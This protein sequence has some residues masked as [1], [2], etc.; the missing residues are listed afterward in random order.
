MKL[1]TRHIG[2][3]ITAL[4][5]IAEQKRRRVSVSE[6]AKN[7]KIPKHFLRKIMQVLN[8]KG[9]LRSYKGRGGGFVLAQAPR[10][11]L[12][13]NLIEIFQG[14]VKLSECIFKKTICPNIQRCKL[15]KKIDVIEKYVISKLKN[16]TLVSLLEKERK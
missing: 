7:L 15:K 4:C 3:A 5:V 11:I 14:P 13:I 6:L 10:K 1:I 9:V 12:L 8:K 2:Y 16:I